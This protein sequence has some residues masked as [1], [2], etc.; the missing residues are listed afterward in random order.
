VAAERIRIVLV[1]DNDIFREALELVLEL[2]DDMEVVASVADGSDAAETCARLEPD[3]VLMDYRMPGL[4]GVQATAAVRAASPTT[5]ILCL[6][7]AADPHEQE[8]LLEAGAVACLSK[9]EEF[10]AIVAAIYRAAGR[11]TPWS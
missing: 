7:A 3:V 6:T 1:E 4:D 9:N 5:R 8:A 2:R 11:E 10:D